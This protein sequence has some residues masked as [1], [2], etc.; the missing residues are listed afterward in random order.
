MKD[1]KGYEGLYAIT[2]CGKVWSYKTKRFL[3]TRKN[4]S[5]Y[6]IVNLCKNGELKTFTIHRLLLKTYCPC[7]NMDKLEA[8]HK[9]EDIT[10]NWLSN[11]EWVQDRAE[12][13]MPKRREKL[14][15]STSRKPLTVMCV[16]TDTVYKSVMAAHRDTGISHCVILRACHNERNT[17]GGY[18]WRIINN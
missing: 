17:A 6:L 5:G 15:I 4:N 1:I 7:E 18:H 2:S 3:S 8:W 13:K 11:L 10:H 9:D 12:I 14:S 16:E